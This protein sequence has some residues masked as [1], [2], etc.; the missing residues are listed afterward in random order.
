[1]G[2][3][4]TTNNVTGIDIN[5]RTVDFI[6]QDISPTVIPSAMMPSIVSNS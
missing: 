1:M 4:I 2:I 5:D 3:D 6:L